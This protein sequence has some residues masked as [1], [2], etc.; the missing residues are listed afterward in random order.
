MLVACFEDARRA[1]ARSVYY[2]YTVTG[3]S[4]TRFGDTKA[5][6]FKEKKQANSNKSSNKA[7]VAT[8]IARSKCTFCGKNEHVNADCCTRN[9][10]FTINQNRPYIGSEAHGRLAVGARE[11]IPNFKE[12]KA[13]I[14]KAG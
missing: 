6:S 11:W 8:A 7:S 13:L 12:L 5:V 14:G 3:N 10:E 1:K 9:S 2:K 4:E